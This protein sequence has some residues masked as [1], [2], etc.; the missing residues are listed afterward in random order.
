MISITY[1]DGNHCG[2]EDYHKL[3]PCPNCARYQMRGDSVITIPADEKKNNHYTPVAAL[4]K[5]TCQKGLPQC[6]NRLPWDC[7]ECR[8]ENEIN[9]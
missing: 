9:Q 5:L 2:Y 6:S 4:G 8:E 3:L 1:K 7:N